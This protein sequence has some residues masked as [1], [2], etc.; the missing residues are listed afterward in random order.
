[1]QSHLLFCT[2]GGVIFEDVSFDER[3][4]VRYFR[5]HIDTKHR[6]SELRGEI[7]NVFDEYCQIR[8]S[9][10]LSPMNLAF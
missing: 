8:V 4:I 9:E 3:A 7:K 10:V 6:Y 2:V 1:M 5:G